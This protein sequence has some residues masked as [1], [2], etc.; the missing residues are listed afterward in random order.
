[1][2]HFPVT[3]AVQVQAVYEQAA[4]AGAT[5]AGVRLAHARWHVADAMEEAG[6]TGFDALS[7]TEVL[8][9]YAA[10]ESAKMG[11]RSRWLV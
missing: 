4:L 9:R 1:M 5:R 11:A 8:R 7:D 6:E 3:D 2:T 10:Y